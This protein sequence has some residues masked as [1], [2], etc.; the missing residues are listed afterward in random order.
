MNHPQYSESE[1]KFSREPYFEKFCMDSINE[2][3]TGTHERKKTTTIHYT[4]TYTLFNMVTWS[5]SKH[6][7]VIM[8]NKNEVKLSFD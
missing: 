2:N 1:I 3:Q 5:K 7:Q 6:L 4:L 8:L